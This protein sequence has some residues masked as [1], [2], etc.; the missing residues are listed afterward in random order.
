MTAALHGK[1]ASSRASVTGY[2]AEPIAEGKGFM[3]QVFRLRLHYDEEPRD[4]PRTL[5]AKLPSADPALRAISDRLGQDRREVRFYQEVAAD[6]RLQTSHSYYCGIDSA[7]GNG[8]LLLEDLNNARQGD[9]V[10][11]GSLADTQRAMA[12]LAESRL[13]GGTAPAWI[14][15]TGCR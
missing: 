12:Q 8:I 2:S 5:I 6:A 15:W 9:S 10:A 1:V 3:N 7:T 13:T 11:G 14:G 4:L